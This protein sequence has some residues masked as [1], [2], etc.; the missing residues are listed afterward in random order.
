VVEHDRA[1]GE[2][3][4]VSNQHF[5]G[6]AATL[7][8]GALRVPAASLRFVTHDIGGGFGNKI[9]IYPYLTA[10]CLLARKLRRPIQWTEWR[11][12]Q[13]LAN[14]HGN[15]R[16]FRDVEVAVMNDG[17][18]LG[19]KV[20]AIDD[21]GAFPRYEPAGCVI[22]SQVAPGC[23]RWRNIRVD[24]TQVVTNKSPAGANRGYSRMQQLW[25]IER[26]IDVVA[27]ELGLDPVEVRKRNYVQA[28]EMPYETPNGSVYDSGD[29]ARSLDVALELIDYDAVK[30]RRGEHDGKLVGIGIGST[31]D[32]GTN[33]FA[34]VRITNPEL[35]ASGNNEAASI[36]LDLFGEIVLALGTAP[37]GQSHETT[38]AQVAADILGVTPDDVTVLR[39]HDSARN[40]HAGFSGT[41]ASQFAVSGLGAV[42]GA[43]TK[44]AAEIKA[45]AAAKLGA[46]SPDDIVLEGGSA[47]R[48]DDP[49]AS[50]SFGE[51]ALLVNTDN[52]GLP[53]G[54]DVSLNC[55]YV[56][57]PP[58]ALPDLERKWGNLTLTYAS[59][60]HACVVEI[61]RTTGFVE[62]V[63]HSAVD[64]CG[65]RVNP[66]VVEGQ[67]HG[68]TAHAIGAAL[69]ETFAYDDD[70][71]L[72]T[73]N[74]YEYHVP[75]ALDVPAIKTGSVESPSPFTPLGAKGM[76]EGGGGA[77]HAVCAA[78][79]DALR[80][81]GIDAVVSDSFNSSERVWRLIN[82]PEESRALVEVVT[83]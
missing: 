57:R 5:P 7:M 31:L 50:L 80:A 81:A 41:Y 23:Y 9:S 30:E 61:D 72:L 4:I 45:L 79:Q 38:A 68:A 83:Q 76:G 78:I 2:Y 13:H 47:R 52:I 75:H 1:T 37:Q 25:M 51:C 6:A 24:M 15:E 11:T 64:D 63:D 59:Q 65:V 60:I 54:L 73:P 18:M 77:L 33:N 22:W 29:Y 19:F 56:Y 43:A 28:S 17:R 58:F 67:V 26:I 36:R 40:A 71:Q 10:C 8:A 46:G 53:P 35:P 32:S 39:G 3:T 20:T 69:G 55:R 16:W 42:T 62:I 74:F 44:L 70:G 34:Q 48:L 66:Q 27:H 49:S 14:A 21:C 82:R 12:D